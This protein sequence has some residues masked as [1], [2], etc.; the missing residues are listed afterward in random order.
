M[1]TRPRRVVR[2]LQ[3]AQAQM[4]K[5]NRMREEARAIERE[6]E[7]LA[8]EARRDAHRDVTFGPV[9]T[10]PRGVVDSVG[11]STKQY[12]ASEHSALK[13]VYALLPWIACLLGKLLLS[14]W[15]SWKVARLIAVALSSAICSGAGHAESQRASGARQEYP[16]LDD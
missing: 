12:G 15:P 2:R 13:D 5:Q 7:K 9:Q 8:K 11:S 1:T 3:Q 10:V 4:A 6:A 16:G 14:E